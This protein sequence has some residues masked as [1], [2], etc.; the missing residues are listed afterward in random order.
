MPKENIKNEKKKKKMWTR[1]V[2]AKNLNSKRKYQ[3]M[4]KMWTHLI[5]AK[6]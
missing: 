5:Y 4:K 6:V 3:K 1:L 2:C